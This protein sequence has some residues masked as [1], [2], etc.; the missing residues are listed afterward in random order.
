MSVLGH[1]IS[2]TGSMN[3][4]EKKCFTALPLALEW[5]SDFFLISEMVNPQT[6]GLSAL[7]SGWCSDVSVFSSNQ[8]AATLSPPTL[9]TSW[10]CSYSWSLPRVE[11]ELCYISIT[12][13]LQDG[14]NNSFLA[15]MK[16]NVHRV[17]HFSEV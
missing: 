14:A 7:Q 1:I 2:G 10:G 9:K 11:K 3:K 17:C 13:V 5:Q 15:L 8:G 12:A 16:S 4:A 6:Q